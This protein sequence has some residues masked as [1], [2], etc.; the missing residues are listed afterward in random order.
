MKLPL[1][2]V[3]D[4][5]R[6]LTCITERPLTV[7][8]HSKVNEAVVVMFDD[9]GEELLHENVLVEVNPQQSVL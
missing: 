9:V 6:A 7:I 2:F 3:V 8:E 5:E 4:G 1:K